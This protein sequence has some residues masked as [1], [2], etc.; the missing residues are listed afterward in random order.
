V[1]TPE[2]LRQ[3][4]REGDWAVVLHRQQVLGAGALACLRALRESGAGVPFVVVTPAAAAG[5]APDTLEALRAAGAELLPAEA[6]PQLAAV[7]RRALERRAA[8]QRPGSGTAALP[9]REERLLRLA[10]N[11]PDILFE[12]VLEPSAQFAYVSPAAARTTGYTPAEHYANPK[13][14]EELVDPEHRVLLRS[15]FEGGAR[16]P[17]AGDILR[18]RH[19]DGRLRWVELRTATVRD[20]AGHVLGI[21]GIV[22]DITERKE[23]E[24]QLLASQRMDAIGRLAGGIAHDFNNMLTVIGAYCNLLRR[25]LPCDHAA[26]GDVQRIESATERA[27]ALV[28]QLMAFG[29]RQPQNLSVLDFNALLEDFAPMLHRLIGEHIRI[30]TEG[31]P[32]PLAVRADRS[33]L[34]QVLMNL[35]VNARDAMPDGG[36]LT[37]RT[38]AATA[39]DLPPDALLPPVAAHY[40]RFS[41][42]DTGV[43][44]TDEVRARIFDPFYTT[45]EVGQGTG[46]GLSTVY[47]IVR[48]M[49]GAIRVSS[50]PGAGSTFD[51]FLPATEAR[52]SRRP[53]VVE[54]GEPG[55]TARI[56]LVEDE[57][58]VREAAREILTAY[59]YTILPAASAA[60]ALGILAAAGE[61]ID[62]LLTDLVMPHMNGLEL[63][64]RVRAL[65]ANIKVLYTTGYTE[66]TLPGQCSPTSTTALLQKPFGSQALLRKVR[67][68]LA[69]GEGE[70]G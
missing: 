32:G 17:R 45:K 51:I 11:A 59:G 14:W 35:V 54:P 12:Y 10:H 50:I 65:N 6:L 47:G 22:R 3:A 5:Q 48:Q 61:Q 13:L 4:L 23:L 31:H 66:A 46:L 28:R 57:P 56:L 25:R 34:E 41:V 7:V 43:G 2:G 39:A 42:T 9:A 21:E 55:G 52:L 30:R 67:E 40:V 15:L 60:D 29:R 53:P 24:A 33:Q 63:A 18:W 16:P 44:M 8:D 68:V 64:R 20:A 49:D 19:R 69:L 37:L 38:A 62:L 58:A 27:A 26:L 36:Q 1:G 70:S